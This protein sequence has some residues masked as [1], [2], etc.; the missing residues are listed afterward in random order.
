MTIHREKH[1]LLGRYLKDIV[2]AANDGIVTTFAVVAGVVG[3]ALSPVVILIIGFASLIA[4]G[5]SMAT[6]NYLGSKSEK[7][8]Y[9]KEEAVEKREIKEIP[10][11]ELEEIRRI[12]KRKG[13]D[14]KNLEEMVRLISSNEKYWLDFMMHEEIGLLTPEAYSPFVSATATFVS[15]IAAGSL[16]LWPYVIFGG[17]SVFTISAVATGVTLFIVGALR[18]FF[19]NRS[20]FASG[21]EM[22]LVG[23][24][25]A[26]L[27]YFAGFFLQ[28]LLS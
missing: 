2:F 18:K 13:Y 17:D 7:E 6:G 14:G 10:E 24:S 26:T 19:S 20:W 1:I 4:D 16:P 22:L 9:L 12:L 28:S 23:G 21:V 25:A 3:A 11:K 8:F 27:A 5:F 15:F